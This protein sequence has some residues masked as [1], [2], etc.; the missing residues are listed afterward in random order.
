MSDATQSEQTRR[1]M[2]VGASRVAGAVRDSG[3]R[4]EDWLDAW[5][6]HFKRW[7]SVREWQA[8]RWQGA[9]IDRAKRTWKR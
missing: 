3:D 1:D 2:P 5:D 8:A 4:D 6:A 9:V 7:V